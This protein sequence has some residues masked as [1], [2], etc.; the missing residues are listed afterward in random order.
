VTTYLKYK[1]RD[2]QQ[3]YCQHATACT[4]NTC[5]G[6][7]SMDMQQMQQQLQPY[8]L[9]SSDAR[10]LQQGQHWAVVHC[11]MSQCHPISLTCAVTPG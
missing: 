1:E 9:A 7:N 4:I 8:E 5:P 3:R 2:G 6:N 10:C 11:S